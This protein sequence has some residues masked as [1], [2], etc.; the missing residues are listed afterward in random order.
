MVNGM[1]IYF[2]FRI[3]V[4]V[5]SRLV[6]RKGVDLLVGIIPNVCRLMKN[7]DFVVGGNG[8]KLLQ[9]QEM[10]ERENLQHRVE[11]L[12]SVPHAQVRDVLIRGHVFLNC[13]LTE[14][15]CIAILEAASCGLLVVSTNVGGVPEVLPADDMILMAKPNVPDMVKCVVMAVERQLL[16]PVDTLQ[17]HDR[18]KHMYSWERVAEETE[19]VYDELRLRPKKS[20]DYRL[21]LYQ[22]SLGGFSGI[23]ACVLAVIVQ[24]W[25]QYVE[26]VQ[27]RERIDLVPDL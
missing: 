23:V 24:I 19:A 27:P 7:V 12:G 9:L 8:N 2:S 1:L 18:I 26:W 13:S 14:S 22:S 4:I 20:L 21:S 15:F 25:Y 10:V 17:M 5:I 11:F 16:H 6:Y 3:K